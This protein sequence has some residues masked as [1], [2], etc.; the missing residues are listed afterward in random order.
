MATPAEHMWNE[1]V[2]KNNITKGN[3]Q[4]RWFGQQDQPDEI[5][6]LNDL[7]LHGQKRSTSK[8]LAYYAAEQEAVPQVG[9]YYVLLNG[10]MKPVA[11]IQTVVSELIPFLR[12]SAEHAYNEG[13]GDLSL[14][15]WRTRSSKKFTELMSH[16]DNKFSEDDPIVTEVFK[17]V[18]SEG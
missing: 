13:E 16:Y 8:P 15:D 12:V 17:V 1:F 18:H 2:E 6:R 9:D 5:D 11:I 4:T 14:E 7:I 10:E 3:F